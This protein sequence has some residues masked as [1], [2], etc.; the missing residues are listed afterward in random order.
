MRVDVLDCEGRELRVRQ[1]DGLAFC[2]RLVDV[3]AVLQCAFDHPDGSDPV[4]RP[5]VDEHRLIAL[6]GDRG[7]EAVDDF[8]IRRGGV[9]RKVNVFQPCRLSGGAARVNVGS[10]FGRQPQIHDRDEAFFLQCRH[11]GRVGRARAPDGCVDPRKVAHAGDFALGH[12]RGRGRGEQHGGGE[13]NQR[14]S[15]VG[16]P[17][18]RFYAVRQKT[19]KAAKDEGHETVKVSCPSSFETSWLNYRSTVT[20]TGSCT[21]TVTGVPDGSVAALRPP[22]ITAA[23]PPPAPTAVPIAA[24]LAPPRMPPMIAPPMAAPPIFAALSLVGESP[25]RKIVSVS[26]GSRVPSASTIDVKRTPRRARSFRR[27]PR[28]TTVTSPWTREPAGIAT[29]SPTRTS[30]VTRAATASSTRAR[31]LVMDDSISRPITESAATTSSSNSGPAGSTVRDAWLSMMRGGS[32]G[33]GA[34]PSSTVTAGAA[35]T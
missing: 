2:A 6:V 20:T 32:I 12:L 15:H 11:R 4:G 24:P 25:S 7:K 8:R 14:R 3:P 29:R 18:R 17:P 33:A 30:R 9:E 19:T 26:I 10:L 34:G 23:L 5:A 31:S 13:Q 28:S 35:S 27:P 1:T 16:I 22:A 21:R